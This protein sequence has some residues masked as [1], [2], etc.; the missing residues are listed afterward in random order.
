MPVIYPESEQIHVLQC[1][2]KGTLANNRTVQSQ[3]MPINTH[4]PSAWRHEVIFLS[5][6][7][8]NLGCQNR[9]NSQSSRTSTQRPSTKNRQQSWKREFERRFRRTAGSLRH[10]WISRQ[11]RCALHLD[12][13]PLGNTSDRTS[14]H[15]MS[16][17]ESDSSPGE[18]GQQTHP[19]SP[20]SR[21]RHEDATP[22]CRHSKTDSVLSGRT[23]TSASSTSGSGC[24]SSSGSHG[25]WLMSWRGVH[26]DR[27]SDQ[28]QW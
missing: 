12:S 13:V 14:W 4:F 7:V 2:N 1:W 21:W 22:T 17:A 28:P 27:P 16:A 6:S 25:N 8:I 5:G 3:F 11:S 18:G 15:R 23:R 20:G 26:T 24:P 19:R 9:P 10:Q